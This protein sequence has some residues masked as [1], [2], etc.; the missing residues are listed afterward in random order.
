M[1]DPNEIAALKASFRGALSS[2]EKLAALAPRIEGFDPHTDIAATDL[3]EL[4]RLTAAH[5]VAA[6]AL[7]GLVNT[8][9]TR[10]GVGTT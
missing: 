4:S 3:D 1:S 6:A 2:A 8:I 10:R 9:Q 7:R 5:A